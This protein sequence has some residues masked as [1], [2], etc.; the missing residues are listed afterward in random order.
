L[1]PP[2][3]TLEGIKNSWHAHDKTCIKVSSADILQ[4][5]V[6][7]ATTRQ[8]HT[9]ESLLPP[10]TSTSSLKRDT[11]KNDF[12]WGRPDEANCDIAWTD[13]L[14]SFITQA[15]TLC[16]NIIPCRCTAAG[17]EIKDKMIDR[18]NFTASKFH[19][20]DSLDTVTHMPDFVFLSFSHHFTEE[21]NVLIG[22]HTIGSL[23]HVFGITP[24]PVSHVTAEAEIRI[25][26]LA[27][28]FLFVHC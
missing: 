23:R 2:L 13:N 22:A 1:H 27:S 5:A 18:N 16:N 21:A 15:N 10:L 6:F 9:P 28:E 8:T 7:F 4:F 26:N 14:P 25:L 20:V 17:N 19:L 24:H 12:Q 3:L 11:L